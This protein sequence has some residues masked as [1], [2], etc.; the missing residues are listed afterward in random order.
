MRAIS[1]RNVYFLVCARVG[2]C[3]WKGTRVNVTVVK[4]WYFV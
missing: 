2:V 3:F 4:F 1:L